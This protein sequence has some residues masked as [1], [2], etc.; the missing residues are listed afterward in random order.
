MVQRP[1]MKAEPRSPN[2]GGPRTPE[3]IVYHIADGGL[4][5]TLSWLCNPASQ[6]SSNYVVA[7]DGAIYELVP[8]NL[9]PWTNGATCNPD[10]TNPLIK[11]WV[12]AG[13]YP[14]APTLTIEH[15]GYS[16]KGKGGS[17]TA[18][19]VAATVAL[20]AW[21]CEVYHLTPDRQHII[22][23]YQLDACTRQNCPGFSPAEWAAWLGKVAAL[24]KGT[25]PVDEQTKRRAAI[26]ALAE[27]I[28]YEAKGELVREGSVDLSGVGGA[29]DERVALCERLAFHSLN[30]KPAV[31]K[32]DV[33]DVLEV[34]WSLE[35]CLARGLVTWW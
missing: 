18:P 29:A 21:L 32:R 20:T 5:G 8:P 2:H 15:I 28:P 26:M 27:S 25:Q 23:H 34:A 10:L 12:G 16:S 19:Q 35:D 24:V 9:T 31:F 11:K 7:R 17:L 3:A 33:P 22:G 14:N 13:V 6:A 30:G 4:D 1:P